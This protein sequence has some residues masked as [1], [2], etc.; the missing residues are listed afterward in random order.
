MSGPTHS[1]TRRWVAQCTVNKHC[2]RHLKENATAAV[3]E[4]AVD[5]IVGEKSI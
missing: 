4:D 2:P 3:Y 5:S 1:P